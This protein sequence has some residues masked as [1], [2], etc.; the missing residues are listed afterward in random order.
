ML[1]AKKTCMYQILTLLVNQKG[2]YYTQ[3][4]LLNALPLNIKI[5]R[6]DTEGLKPAF[7]EYIRPHFFYCER[8][9]TSICKKCTRFLASATM[10]TKS[11]LS[12]S[13]LRNITVEHRPQK[14]LN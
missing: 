7:K 11:A 12:Y 14:C 2:V 1:E 9:F 10:Y 5:C 6:N 8:E 4:K 3:I 13:T